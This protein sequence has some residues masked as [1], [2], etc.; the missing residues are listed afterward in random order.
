M[1]TVMPPAVHSTR[2]WALCGHYAGAEAGSPPAS[3]QAAHRLL[4]P[5]LWGCAPHAFKRGRAQQRFG[6]QTVSKSVTLRGRWDEGGFCKAEPGWRPRLEAGAQM[7][8]LW[9]WGS[10]GPQAQAPPPAPHWGHGM[11]EQWVWSWGA[12]RQLSRLSPVMAEPALNDTLAH[13]LRGP[14]LITLL[15]GLEIQHAHTWWLI[16]YFLPYAGHLATRAK[17]IHST[18]KR[19]ANKYLIPCHS[20]NKMLNTQTQKV[21]HNWPHGGFSK[22]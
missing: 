4:C 15:M 18:G 5:T 13:Q 19:C 21:T 10:G 11:S 2:L 14:H 1:D 6:P 7:E 3:C 9:S 17:G 22:N 20:K 12:L 8:P 16:P